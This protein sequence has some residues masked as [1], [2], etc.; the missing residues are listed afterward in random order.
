MLTYT[1]PGT[2]GSFPKSQIKPRRRP[3]VLCDESVADCQELVDSVPDIAGI[4]NRLSSEEVQTLL[5]DSFSSES[6]AENRSS[7]SQRY[8]TND[9]VQ[10]AFDKLMAE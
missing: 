3:S 2:P 7:E 10:S 9:S 5:D 1:V 8:N 6:S 4:F